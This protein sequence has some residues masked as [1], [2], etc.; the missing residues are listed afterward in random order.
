MKAFIV[1]HPL[2]ASLMF[3]LSDL[4]FVIF[5]IK[6][7]PLLVPGMPDTVVKLL[8]LAVQLLIVIA[9]L[10]GLGW[11]REAGF[12][13]P[14]QWHNLHLYWLPLLLMALF[15]VLLGVHYGNLAALVP[16]VIMALVIGFQEDVVFRGLIVR[17]NLPHG[18]MRTVLT[19]AVLFGLIHATALM[20]REPGF[21]AAQI[22]ASLLGGIGLAALRLRSNTIWP[23]VLL[24]AYNDT[25]QF[26][27]VG[28]ANYTQIPTTLI[29]F[30]LVG[31]IIL[32]VYGFYLVRDAWWPRR[33]RLVTEPV[34]R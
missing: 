34:G 22:I 11:W 17:A 21:V 29:V 31:P 26:L 20:F 15:P 14:S 19:S 8:T 28:G 30:K 23:L 33:E 12:N 25:V 1:R 24:H 5:G 3:A 9:W 4:P 32:A 7:L 10:T 6:V 13:R 2:L 18:T 27:A 16:I